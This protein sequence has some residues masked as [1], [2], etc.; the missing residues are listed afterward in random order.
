MSKNVYINAVVILFIILLVIP[1]AIAEEDEEDDEPG[2]FGS[3]ISGIVDKIFDTIKSIL[4]APIKPLVSLIRKMLSAVV[5]LDLFKSLWAVILYTLS[6]FYSLLL[7]YTGF[8]FMISGY[9]ATKRENAKQWLRN[10]VIMVVLVQGSFFL[11]KVLIELSAILTTAILNMIPNDF[12]LITFESI[13]DIIFYMVYVLVLLITALLLLIRY[14]VVSFG[15]V[16]FPIGIFLYFIP[17]TKDYGKTILNFLAICVF[18]SFFNAVILLCC[19]KL[20]D[21]AVFEH[22]KILVMIASFLLVFLNT[23]YFMFFSLI[24]SAV[25]V[26]GNFSGTVGALV[27][28]FN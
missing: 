19:S 28:K 15:V 14:L 9:D 17:F 24:K 16:F 18:I 11:Y 6:L 3:I 8:N 5:N 2:W 20:I 22:F 23:F 26:A 10:I 1:V 4:N 21:I 13:A 7:L 27:K 25:S 12:F